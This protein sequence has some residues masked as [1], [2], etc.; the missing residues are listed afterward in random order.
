MDLQGEKEIE[1]YIEES[2]SYYQILL[3]ERN[4]VEEK[5]ESWLISL[6]II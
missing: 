4:L 5:L 3:F 6:L 1:K 2:N